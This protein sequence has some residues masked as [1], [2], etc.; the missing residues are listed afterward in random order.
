[1]CVYK[2]TWEA[3]GARL[4]SL[5]KIVQLLALSVVAGYSG[6]IFRRSWDPL[7][8]SQLRLRG[9]ENASDPARGAGN[10]IQIYLPTFENLVFW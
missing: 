6:Q 5:F 7:F 3:P 2:G 9:T 4:T 1:M 8:A 10:Y